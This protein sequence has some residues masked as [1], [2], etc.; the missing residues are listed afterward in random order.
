MIK[1]FQKYWWKDRLLMW[2]IIHT[3]IYHS[4]HWW[5]QGGQA[6]C[7]Q[8]TQ[9][10]KLQRASHLSFKQ[11][12]PQSVSAAYTQKKTKQRPDTRSWKILLVIHTQGS[13][14]PHLYH[15]YVI[16]EKQ[17]NMGLNTWAGTREPTMAVDLKTHKLR[18]TISPQWTQK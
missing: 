9:C 7:R 15:L 6:D 14:T 4:A 8:P 10:T 17:L 13:S 18:D 1:V 3:P 5:F 16:K 11:I 12:D 2:C